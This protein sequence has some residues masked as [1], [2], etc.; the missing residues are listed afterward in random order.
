LKRRPLVYEELADKLTKQKICVTFPALPADK[1]R[2]T[3]YSKQDKIQMRKY[4]KKGL[5]YT[6]IA[7]LMKCSY[8]TVMSA[9]DST[10]RQKI[11]ARNAKYNRARWKNAT[12]KEKRKLLDTSSESQRIRYA[13]DPEFRCHTAYRMKK[14][15]EENL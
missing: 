10:A 12:K 15:R 2:C 1:K 9:C 14:W 5:S 11:Y 6:I 7:Q 13:N 4:H 3:K 8:N